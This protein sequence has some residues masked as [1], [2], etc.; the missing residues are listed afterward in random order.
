MSKARNIAIG[1]NKNDGYEVLLTKYRHK[2]PQA[3]RE[4][5]K[6]KIHS[7]RTNVKKEL[8]RTVNSKK[9]GA[10]FEDKILASWCS[11]RRLD[12]R[13]SRVSHQMMDHSFA[14]KSHLAH[15]AISL[16]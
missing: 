16:S 2:F 4:D 13:Q 6:N 3:G 8:H 11:V 10:G 7:P 5:V 1:K 15:E 9:S 14:K 12:G